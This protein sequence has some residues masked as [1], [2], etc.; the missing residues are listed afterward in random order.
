MDGGSPIPFDMGFFRGLSRGLLGTPYTFFQYTIILLYI[1]GKKCHIGILCL[2]PS[3]D[4]GA[5]ASV[6]VFL[7]PRRG[8]PGVGLLR[9]LSRVHCRGYSGVFWGLCTNSFNILLLFLL[10]ILVYYMINEK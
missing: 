1:F 2:P 6:G 7:G 4:S 9:G 8:P 10:Y 5:A 3:G